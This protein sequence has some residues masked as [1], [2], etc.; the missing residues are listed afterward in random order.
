MQFRHDR[1]RRVLADELAQAQ[2]A[3]TSKEARLTPP[4]RAESYAAEARRDEQP[5]LI[6]LIPK[7]NLTFAL[8]SLAAVAGIAALGALY[9]YQ[10]QIAAWLGVDAI[11][12]FDLTQRSSIAQ[13]ASSALLGFATMLSLMIYSL[14]R[15]RVD[16]Y[17]RRYRVWLL[18]ALVCGI[19]S[20]NATAHIFAIVRRPFELA[21][22]VSHVSGATL[23]AALQ[24]S[25]LATG[26]LRL[27]FEL[28]RSRAA[29]IAWLWTA[30]CLATRTITGSGWFPILEPV[31]LAL[32]NGTTQLTAV[33]SLL[34]TFAF[35][36]RFILLEIEGRLQQRVRRERKPRKS[37]PTA[38][39]DQ[40]DQPSKPKQQTTLRT[41]LEPVAKDK[42][43]TSSKE[44][45]VATPK[46]KLQ[47]ESAASQQPQQLS[48]ADRKKLK[49]EMRKQAA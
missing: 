33:A 42:P 34:F 20:V 21:A 22:E 16:D 31:H 1:R 30:S 3:R 41:D 37:E 29:L 14:R 13:W 18:A 43:V 39:A 49:R 9:L 24:L 8:L 23:T 46:P 2:P 36:E 6:D 19:F 10:A 28:R 38:N 45:V 25:L 26:T 17:H 27:W 32:L 47:W 48:R 5:R 7:R 11:A 44:P 12:A 35:Y 15:W 4:E 40:P